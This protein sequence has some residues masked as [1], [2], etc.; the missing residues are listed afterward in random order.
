M[1]ICLGLKEK[2]NNIFPLR[3]RILIKSDAYW[4]EENEDLKL[5]ELLFSG[6][7]E[8]HALSSPLVC[9]R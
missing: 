8:V 9:A 4:R 2:Q 1:G 6:H 5:K 3:I 7:A